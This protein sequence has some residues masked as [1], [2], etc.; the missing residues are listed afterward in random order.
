MSRPTC[1]DL[2]KAL[3]TMLGVGGPPTSKRGTA[4]R[5][6]PGKRKAG[7]RGKSVKL[8]KP[9]PRSL[10]RKSKPKM[11]AALMTNAR[12]FADTCK[13]DQSKAK[14]RYAKKR[15]SNAKLVALLNQPIKK[16]R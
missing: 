5:V 12:R 6:T 3:R 10:W 7:P 14:G 2:K 13:V 1:R 15:M 4:V 11:L 8:R 9:S 16:G